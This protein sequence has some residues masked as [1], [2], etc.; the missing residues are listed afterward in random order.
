MARGRRRRR[1]YGDASSKN[2][3]GWAILVLCLAV[4]GAVFW[5]HQDRQA[6]LAR[7]NQQTLCRSTGPVAVTA[8]LI[9]RTDALNPV[10]RE[11]TRQALESV[12]NAVKTGGLL[13]LYSVGPTDESVREPIIELC[14]PGRG[15]EVS[16]LDDNPRF[17][18]SRWRDGFEQPLQEIFRDIVETE[19]ASRSPIMESIQSVS[20][21]AFGPDDRR[22]VPRRLVLIS[23]ML[24]HTDGVSHYRRFVPFD[25]FKETPYYHKVRGDLRDVEAEIFYIWRETKTQIQGKAHIQFWRDL[26]A[27]QGGTLVRVDSIEG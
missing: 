19:G 14:N 15:E 16:A 6:A 25:E 22:A 7:L 12:K 24:Q 17:V 1:M 2:A 3:I 4:A 13:Q 11:A 27:D 21:T 18:E 9:D 8:V 5:W 20:V 26:I 23:D 10:Q